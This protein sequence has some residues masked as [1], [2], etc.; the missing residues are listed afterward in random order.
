VALEIGVEVWQVA[1]QALQDYRRAEGQ[2]RKDDAWD[3]SLLA[4]MG[5][6]RMKSCRPAL[7]PRPEENRLCRLSR[8]KEQWTGQHTRLLNQLR[9]RL[10]ELSGDLV[11]KDW[12][13]PRW[14]SMRLR[15]VLKRWPG[16]EGLGEAP[17]EELA[18]TLGR[19]GRVVNNAQEAQA[20]HRLAH[21]LSLSGPARSV[22]TLE[23]NILVQQLDS[24]EEVLKQV[25]HELTVA[26]REH[27]K[28]KA[29]QEMPGVGIFGAAV[30][31]GETLPLARYASE[32][33]VAT[34]AGVTPLARQSGKSGPRHRLARQTNK[35]VLRARYLGAVAACRVSALDQEYYRK[36]RQRHEGHPAAHVKA[37]LSLARQRS[38]LIYKLLTQDE[39]RYDKEILIRSHLERRRK[40]SVENSPSSPKPPSP[41]PAVCRGMEGCRPHPAPGT[42]PHPLENATRF[43][44]PTGHGDEPPRGEEAPTET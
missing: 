1:P 8:L 18:Q 23:L 5:F 14:D 24:V 39:I 26:V 32:S 27:P 30:E 33:Q 9:S 34:Y 29:L 4:R 10:L 43:P 15:A 22:L 31:I 21:G 3:A 41:R 44:Q 13:G 35:R 42:L 2:P 6:L 37:L 12:A 38:K 17:V 16:L 19:V 28:G 7:C 20:L 11:A 40:V 36:Q 25:K